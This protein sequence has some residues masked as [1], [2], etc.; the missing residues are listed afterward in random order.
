MQQPRE[1]LP[2]SPQQQEQ[3]ATQLLHLQQQL[4]H[5]QEEAAAFRCFRHQTP[6]TPDTWTPYCCNSFCCPLF[7]CGGL[8]CL[9]TQQEQYGRM[10]LSNAEILVLLQVCLGWGGTAACLGAWQ[11]AGSA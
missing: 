7:V 11:Y 8:L 9:H 5:L 4:Q 10:P 3:H 2:P 6:W 1:P